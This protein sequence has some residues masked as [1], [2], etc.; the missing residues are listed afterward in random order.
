MAELNSSPKALAERLAELEGR[1]DNLEGIY[2]DIRVLLLMILLETDPLRHMDRMRIL[3]EMG[4]GQEV[5]DLA[6]QM[7][8]QHRKEAEP[9]KDSGEEE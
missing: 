1:M 9:P 2:R 7:I 6:N 4:I 5:I 8:E 3:L